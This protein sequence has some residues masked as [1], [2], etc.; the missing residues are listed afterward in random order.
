MKGELDALERSVKSWRKKIEKKREEEGKL[1]N[2]GP[3]LPLGGAMPSFLGVSP[4][5]H[6]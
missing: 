2:S 5:S 1:E 6:L 4:L 3:Y